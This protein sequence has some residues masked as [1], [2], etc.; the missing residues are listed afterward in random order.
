MSHKTESGLSDRS[1]IARHAGTVL[2][3]QLAVMAFGVTD[4]IVAGR[5]AQES[6]AALAI[7]SALYISVYVPLL[8]M[9]SALLPIWAELRGARKPQAIGGSLRQ[10]LY[11]CALACVPG[12]AVLLHPDPVLAWTQVPEAL[13]PGVEQYLAVLALALPPALLFRV[14][15]TLNQALGHPQWV[16][17]LQVVSLLVKIPLSIWWTFGGAGMPAMGVVGCGWATLVVNC[18]ML[19]VALWLLRTQAMYAPLQVWQRMEPPNRAQLAAF[20]RLGIP[21]ALAVTV[22]VTSFTLM[23]LFIAR[24][25]TLASA[26]HQIAANMAAVL[27]MVPLSL[28]IATSARVSY[29][30]GAGQAAHARQA[31]YIGFRLL[32]L[33]CIALAAIIFIANHWIASVYSNDA[34]V[35]MAAAGLLGWVALYHL[36][37]AVQTLCIFL[38]RCFRITLAPLVVY[39]VM[40]WGVGLGGG[41]LWAYHGFGPVAS[42]ASPVPFWA[43]SAAALVVTAVVFAAMLRRALLSSSASVPEEGAR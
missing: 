25:G 16:T 20:A 34:Q 43:A 37:D 15:S 17:W 2:V 33:I 42:L 31:V 38:L 11:L 23:A 9:L 18:G 14:F 27:Y 5:H 12:M 32:A 28:A 6:L 30:R 13:R 40:L 41:Y 10:S 8:G 35:V 1:L 24:Q 4:T 29:W 7:G 19:A 36:A 26:A 22:E 21:S 39:G 3:G